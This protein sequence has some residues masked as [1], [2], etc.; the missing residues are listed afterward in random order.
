MKEPLKALRRGCRLVS[1]LSF[2]FSPA[3]QACCSLS[4]HYP[5]ST[6]LWGVCPASARAALVPRRSMAPAASCSTCIRSSQCAVRR[7]AGAICE[8]A[9]RQWQGRTHHG[10]N[11]PHT[12]L[13]DMLQHRHELIPSW[14]DKL[15][16]QHRSEAMAQSPGAVPRAQTLP[17][18]QGAQSS[19]KGPECSPHSTLKTG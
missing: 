19:L 6:Q 13:D 18:L 11:G 4:R 7:A 10:L 5:Q 17:D 1:M 12:R 14:L 3:R 2:P 16:A 8:L 9:I 15:A